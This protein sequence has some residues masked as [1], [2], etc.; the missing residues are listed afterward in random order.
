MESWT[1]PDSSCQRIAWR[2]ISGVN[3]TKGLVRSFFKFTMAIK[4]RPFEEHWMEL[5]SAIVR[6]DAQR[7]CRRPRVAKKK[8]VDSETRARPT[9][10]D[11]EMIHDSGKD[12]EAHDQSD[13]IDMMR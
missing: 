13:E 12:G 8:H 6:Q 1:S 10:D 3:R 5:V 4:R 2:Q 7:C 9:Q 11:V